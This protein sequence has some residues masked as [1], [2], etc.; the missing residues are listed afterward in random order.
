MIDKDSKINDDNL[1]SKDCPEEIFTEGFCDLI[2]YSDIVKINL[3]SRPI[4]S[5]KHL[6]SKKISKTL[7]FTKLNFENF[8]KNLHNEYLNINSQLDESGKNAKKNLKSEET[9]EK[10][11]PK[12]GSKII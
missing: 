6:N 7:T 1:L 10:E 11:K 8:L 2:V 12:K 4:H 5:K 3:F 9:F